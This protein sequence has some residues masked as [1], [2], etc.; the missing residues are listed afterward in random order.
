MDS[1]IFILATLVVVV[2]SIL[3]ASVLITLFAGIAR[4]MRATATRADMMRDHIRRM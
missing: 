1:I 3:A 2:G 4:N